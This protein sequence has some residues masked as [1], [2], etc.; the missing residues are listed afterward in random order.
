VC[1]KCTD[2]VHSRSL[3][4]STFSGMGKVLQNLLFIS[5]F[6]SGNVLSWNLLWSHNYGDDSLS[7]RNTDF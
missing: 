7:H 3:S 6:Y 5:M 1:I 4:L 2:D